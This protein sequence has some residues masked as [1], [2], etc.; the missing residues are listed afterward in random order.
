MHSER[1]EE[2]VFGVLD[3]VIT[4]LALVVGVDGVLSHA[5][6]DITS[7]FV[8]LA[9]LAATLGGMMSMFVG[10]WL[11]ARSRQKVIRRERAREEQH[12]AELP[13]LEREHLRGTFRRQGFGEPEVEILV[14]AVT[15]DTKRWVDVMM[16]DELK[17]PT[18]SEPQPVTHGAVI[19]VAYL[20][21]G[22]LPAA[23]F[24]LTSSL[25]TGLWAS[26]AIG[27]IQLAGVG[28]VEAHF[29]GSSPWRGAAEVAAIGLA[30][31][32]AVFLVTTFFQGLPG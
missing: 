31:A 24:L 29:G 15:G 12:I 3:G 10:A 9:I 26:L 6:G 19:G 2:V 27:G 32:F 23:P 14:K 18:E 1:L 17:L 22:L 21:G 11:S 7:R 4:S 13:E 25:Q 16:R 20:L 5:V 30:A 8:F 28:F